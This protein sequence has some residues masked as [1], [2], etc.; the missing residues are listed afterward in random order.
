MVR[1]LCSSRKSPDSIG[2]NSQTGSLS[3]SA[4]VDAYWLVGALALFRLDIVLPPH[5]V[6][7][8]P[9]RSA[10]TTTTSLDRSQRRKYFQTGIVCFGFSMPQLDNLARCLQPCCSGSCLLHPEPCSSSLNSYI[11]H[12]DREL[13][14][15]TLTNIHVNQ[16]FFYNIS[17][18]QTLRTH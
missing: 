8:S 2:I 16:S 6:L 11:V 13:A 7:F 1:E 10:L 3:D 4:Y 17:Y 12:V 14:P 15:L 9:S 18:S 5:L